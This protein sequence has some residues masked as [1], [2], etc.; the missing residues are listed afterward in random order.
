MSVADTSSSR[1]KQNL[2]EGRDYCLIPE[3]EWKTLVESYGLATD[4]RPIPRKVV[5]YSHLKR[6]EV[7][8][9]L[10]KLKLAVH[11]KL[12]EYVIEEFSRGD[13]VGEC[14]TCFIHTLHHDSVSV[15]RVLSKLLIL[16]GE[17]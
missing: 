12:T 16:G 11:P 13:T 10:L 6:C 3:T 17:D 7:E 8:V 14:I 9:Y 15:V 1:L 4:S 5:E 2:K